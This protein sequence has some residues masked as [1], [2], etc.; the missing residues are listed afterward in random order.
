MRSAKN[1]DRI[2]TGESSGIQARE[3]QPEAPVT[4]LLAAVSVNGGRL[5]VRS[6][7]PDQGRGVHDTCWREGKVVSL[8]TMS[9][10]RHDQDPHLE[11]QGCFTRRREVDELVLGITGQGALA[12]VVETASDEPPP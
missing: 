1:C 12:D 4:P 11:L 9:I 7:E 3:A 10:R 2:G 8:L 5:Q 6:E